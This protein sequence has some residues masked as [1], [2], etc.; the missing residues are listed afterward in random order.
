MVP[1]M[2]FKIS[3]SA[4]LALVRTIRQRYGVEARLKWPND[5]LVG[6]KKLSGMLSEME[7]ESDLIKYMNIGLGVNV[8][9]DPRKDE[10]ESTSLKILLNKTVSKTELLKRFM[11]EFESILAGVESKDI[12]SAWKRYSG[13]INQFVTVVTVNETTQGVAVDVDDSGAL[14]L[15]LSDGSVKKMIYGDCFHGFSGEN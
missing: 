4:S 2:S 5:I 8:N 11:G 14:L 3:F 6:N 10:P 15:A 13:T 9:N 7:T 12:V 1:A